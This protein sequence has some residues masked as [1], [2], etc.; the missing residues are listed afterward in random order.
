M[1]TMRELGR[2]KIILPK[3][4]IAALEAIVPERGKSSFIAHAIEEKLERECWEAAFAK[5]QK[6]PPTLMHI[7][8]SVQW[9]EQ[10]RREDEQRLE[11]FDL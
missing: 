2:L 1:T 7:T 4:T 10:L 8:D 6:P 3:R 9:V 5:L 11:H